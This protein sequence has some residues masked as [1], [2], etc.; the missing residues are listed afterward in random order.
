[1]LINKQKALEILGRFPSEP[2]FRSLYGNLTEG[3]TEAVKDVKITSWSTD[4]YEGAEIISTE[5]K[6]FASGDVGKYIRNAFPDRSKW[7]D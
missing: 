1:M 4:R 2:M 6:A 5:D 7:E 3:V